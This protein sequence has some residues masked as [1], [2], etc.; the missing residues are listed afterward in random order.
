MSFL[1]RHTLT[2]IIG[3]ILLWLPISSADGSFTNPID[4]L[5]TAT[6]SICV[7]GLVTV[8]TWAHWSLFGEIVI[9]LLIQ[10]GGLGVITFTTIVLMIL[11][12][13]ITM[14]ERLL[15]QDA[16]NLDTLKGLVRLTLKILKGTFILEGIGA[17]LFSIVFIRDYGFWEGIWKSIFNS[18]SAFCN[19]GMDL[20]GDNSLSPYAANPIINFTT[21]SLIVLGGIGFPVWW[22]ILHMAKSSREQNI[23]LRSSI[24]R[25]NLHTK[26]VIMMT[27]VLILGG[28]LVIFIFEYSN[29]ATIGNF[30]LPEKLMASLFQSVT[31]RTA[32]FFTIPQDALREPTAFISILLMFVGGSPSGTA[33]G[34][35]TVTLALIIL[36]VISIVKGKNDTEAFGRKI[37]ENTVKKG[38][39]V[40]T[41]NTSVLIISVIGLSFVEAAVPFLDVLYETTS[42]LGTVG[43]TRNLTPFLS[44]AGKLI[45]I[46]TMYIGR[47]GPISMAL[48]FNS[49]KHLNVRKLPEENVRV[50]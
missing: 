35:K 32:G 23:S 18:I 40:L 14:K 39:A 27:L 12:R 24:H 48:F 44:L 11:R 5:F 1:K 50:G 45:I 47:V 38:M 41:L 13:R 31:T 29:E 33:G 4:A 3:A 9:V 28:M 46:V 34:I 42:A 26:V 7:T 10:I 2:I 20:I 6:T 16:Y 15:I 21:M 30:P 19:A 25:L 43:L 36:A 49:R 8:P 17:L 37:P 22:D